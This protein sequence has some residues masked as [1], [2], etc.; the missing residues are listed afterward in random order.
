MDV[1][2][3]PDLFRKDTSTPEQETLNVRSL[4]TE[5]EAALE[6]VSPE[7]ATEPENLAALAV[8][9]PSGDPLR[10][11]QSVY[12]LIHDENP[13]AGPMDSRTFSTG[14]W[15]LQGLWEIREVLRDEQRGL[16]GRGPDALW[17]FMNPSRRQGLENPAEAYQQEI[18]AKLEA[19]NLLLRH[20]GADADD[21]DRSQVQRARWELSHFTPSGDLHVD[22]VQFLRVTNHPVELD[23][24]EVNKEDPE[25]VLTGIYMANEQ[26]LKSSQQPVTR[27]AL[28]LYRL[29]HLAPLENE[30]IA[31]LLGKVGL[32]VDVNARHDA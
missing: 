4:G 5:Q 12:G 2:Q 32:E 26:G 17:L 21:W 6:E 19:V 1:F 29:E 30:V 25:A 27:T 24:I 16:S 23:R 28:E 9:Q 15:A 8:F 3:H 10:D 31:R 22:T 7:V 18:D 13:V 20:Y 11:W 14:R